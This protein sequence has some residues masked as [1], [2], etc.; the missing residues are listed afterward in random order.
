M[1]ERNRG[2]DKEHLSSLES[3]IKELESQITVAKQVGADKKLDKLEQSLITDLA[4]NEDELEPSLLLD[5]Q[6]DQLPEFTQAKDRK[7]EYLEESV[8]QLF[9][10]I[11]SKLDIQD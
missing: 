10:Y 6:L 5:E 7:P 4:E 2:Y 8:Y 9:D 3:K 1:I 11:D